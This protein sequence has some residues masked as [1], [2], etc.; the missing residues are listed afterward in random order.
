MAWKATEA[1][2]GP[3]TR[4]DLARLTPNA[5]A[6]RFMESMEG[7]HVAVQR[8]GFVKA[9]E[10]YVCYGGPWKVWKAGM[11]QFREQAL[12][13]LKK[14]ARARFVL[15]NMEGDVHEKY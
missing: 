11:W 5:L 2:Q 6:V 3:Q 14:D 12:L 13:R 10:E 7:W 4:R 1:G 8:A 9:W 15:M